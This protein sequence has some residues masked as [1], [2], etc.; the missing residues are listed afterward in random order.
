MEEFEY[1]TKTLGHG[2]TGHRQSLEILKQGEQVKKQGLEE[3]N[4]IL[5][6]KGCSRLEEERANRRQLQKDT[7]EGVETWT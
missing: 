4:Q 5:H 2:S 6:K 7:G 1:P 3:I